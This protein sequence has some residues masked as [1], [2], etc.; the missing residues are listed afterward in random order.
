MNRL[1]VFH[2]NE[3]LNSNDL[4]K[5]FFRPF[6]SFF[7]DFFKEFNGFEKTFGIEP[8]K[9]Q[10]FPKVDIVQEKDNINGD[11]SLLVDIPGFKKDEV[12]IEIKNASDDSHSKVLTI[13]AE[14]Q[15][16]DEQK[17]KYKYFLKERKS[18]AR[19]SFVFSDEIFDEDKIDAKFT[20][21]GMLTITLPKKQVIQQPPKDEVKKIKIK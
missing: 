5:E 15:E 19:R 20:D 10:A 16:S 14:K 13:W 12:G 18:S 6:D 2:R 9:K 1:P 4:R 8:A 7:D 17:D 21:D 3:L 11:V